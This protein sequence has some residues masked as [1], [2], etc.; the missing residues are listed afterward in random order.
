MKVR[1]RILATT[2]ALVLVGGLSAALTGGSALGAVNNWPHSSIALKFRGTVNLSQTVNASATSGGQ[3][4]PNE[5]R[6]DPRETFKEAREQRTQPSTS[7]IPVPS[8]GSTPI[9][10][11]QLPGF[12][13]WDGLS[14]LDQRYA[15]GGQQLT[16]EPPDQGLCAS[17]DFVME[18]VNLAEQIYDAGSPSGIQGSQRLIAPVTENQFFL[19]PPAVTRPDPTGSGGPPFGPFLSDPKCYYDKDTDRWF[20][21]ILIIDQDPS[22]GAFL[23]SARTGIAVSKGSDPTRTW[24]VYE[25]NSTDNTHPGCPCFG[26]QPLLGADKY[27]VY[28]STA[29]YNLDC[30]GGD[31]GFNGPQVYAFPKAQLAAGATGIKGVH[32]YNLHAGTQAGCYLSGTLQPATSPQ[33]QYRTANNGTEFLMQSTDT[34][35]CDPFGAEGSGPFNRLIIWGMTNTKSLGTTNPS[36]FLTALAIGSQPYALPVPQDQKAG[37]RPLGQLLNEPLP[38]PTANDDRMNQVVYAAGRLWGGV[39]TRVNPGPHDGLAWFQVKVGIGSN[40]NVTGSVAKQGYLANDAVDLSFPSIGVNKD[41]SGIMTF[42]LMGKDYYPSAAYAPITLNGTGSIYIGGHGFDPDDGFS[43]Y[44]EFGPPSCRWGDYSAAVASPDGT[45]IWWAT[46]YI[47]DRPRTD[48]ANW[49]T[50][51]GRAFAP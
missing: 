34:V 43:C 26:D 13:G 14:H 24:N 10:G 39:N 25:F 51:I 45:K 16:L 30:F 23:P 22:T 47:P 3:M 37:P 5:I 44:P 46:E 21:T 32:F 38:H 15:N 18:G 28:V 40:N 8:P 12:A 11:G 2:V 33:A 36:P 41:G 17:T 49:G 35:P 31:C 27:G 6:Y 4:S 19:Y 7:A 42:S 9:S 48:L 1:R 20:H 29:E 50:F